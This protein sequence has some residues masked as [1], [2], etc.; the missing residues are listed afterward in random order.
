MAK[1]TDAKIRDL[2]IRAIHHAAEARA[3]RQV[4]AHMLTLMAVPSPKGRLH[5][6]IYSMKHKSADHLPGKFVR[7]EGQKAVKDRAANEAYRNA[8]YVYGF[9]KELFGRNSIDGKGM[10]LISSVHVGKHYCN[11]FWTGKQMAYGDGHGRVFLRFTRGLDCSAH[12]MTHGVIRHTCN[13][14]YVHEPGALN[15]HF[16]DVMGSLVKQWAQGQTVREA[17]WLIGEKIMGPAL[18]AKA[19]RTLKGEKAYEN[20]PILGTDPQPK[21]MKNYFRGTAIRGQSAV[22]INSGIPNHAFYLAAMA[23]GGHAWNRAGTIWYKSMLS[24]KSDSGFHEAAETTVRV[25]GEEYGRGSREQKAV[26][27]AWKA[28]GV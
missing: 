24:L 8:G 10:S 17:N 26:K 19:I 28:V 14:A 25:A 20:D 13:L 18:K 12:E 2:G 27:A 9:Y 1:S 22:H 4:P 11:A 21:H 7:S 23:L 3:A 15:E 6:V 16:A 5:Q